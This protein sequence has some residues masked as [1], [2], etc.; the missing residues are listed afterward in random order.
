M[1]FPTR[2]N[3]A[4]P[5]TA[6]ARSGAAPAR[7]RYALKETP[8]QV[9]RFYNSII[10]FA[11]NRQITGRVDDLRET[12]NFEGKRLYLVPFVRAIALPILRTRFGQCSTLQIE[13]GYLKHGV[14]HNAA[15]T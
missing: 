8:V 14:S 3:G 1:V 2:D 15:Q 12:F 10:E 13:R 6:D 9:G 4:L 11:G 7:L 5:H